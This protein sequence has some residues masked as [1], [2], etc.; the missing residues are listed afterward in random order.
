[1][2]RERSAK[3]LCAGSIPARAS[4]FSLQNSYFR[5]SGLSSTWIHE[6]V[7]FVNLRVFWSIF[8][9]LRVGWRTK[10]GQRFV[11]LG[12]AEEHLVAQSRWRRRR[13]DPSRRCGTVRTNTTF[14]DQ[15]CSVLCS[16]LRL[17][18]LRGRRYGCLVSSSLRNSCELR[19]QLLCLVYSDVHFPEGRIRQAHLVSEKSTNCHFPFILRYC[20]RFTG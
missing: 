7:F 6:C 17:R 11:S 5:G 8:V 3:P 18:D 10:S 14:P 20:L 12:Q 2:V 1:M 13:T 19:I 4:K 15:T 16:V 9:R